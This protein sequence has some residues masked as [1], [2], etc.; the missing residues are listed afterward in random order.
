[1]QE[2]RGL[3][4]ETKVLDAE[5]GT[6]NEEIPVGIRHNLNPI[7]RTGAIVW[8]EKYRDSP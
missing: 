5:I 7:V 8:K 6:R 1:M 3:V 4:V 2:R